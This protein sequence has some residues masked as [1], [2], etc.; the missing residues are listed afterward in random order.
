MKN[1]DEIKLAKELISFP[2]IKTEDKGIMRFL[3]KKLSSMGFKCKIIKSKGLGSKPALNLF[4]KLGNSRPHINF[5]G[6]T[7]VVLNLDNWSVPPFK[8]VLK[9]AIYM[10]EVLKI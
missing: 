4:A 2:T 1:F 3:S 6:H 5:L 10:E 9:M 8:A 7:D